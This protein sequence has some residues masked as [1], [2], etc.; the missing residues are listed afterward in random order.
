VALVIAA[1]AVAAFGL[2]PR[3]SAAVAWTALGLVVALSIFGPTIRL[4][5]WVLDLSPFTH[6]PRL[7]GG[8]VAVAPLLWLTAVTVTVTAAGIAAFRCRDI[9]Y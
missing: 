6:A 3:A 4:S 8:T 7:P 2:A 5:H 1:V 9:S